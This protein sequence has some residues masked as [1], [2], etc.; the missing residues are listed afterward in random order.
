M[1][2]KIK[3][4][5]SYSAIREQLK[6][7]NA[8]RKALKVLSFAGIKNK[9]LNKILDQVPAMQ[10]QWEELTSAPDRFN[11]IFSAFG[12]IAHESMNSELMERAVTLAEKDKFE[13][14]NNLLIN[15]YCSE[16]IKWPI[17]WLK[18]IPA[19]EKRYD[20]I[21]LAYKDSLNERY[22][23]AV[24]PLLMIIDGGVNDI[25]KNKGFFTPSTDL[26][27][28]DSIAAHS[29]GLSVIRNVFNAKRNK[30]NTDPISLPYRNG[31]LHGRD[32]NYANK[33]VTAKCWATLI[34]IHDWAKAIQEKRKAPPSA[35]ERVS[36]RETLIKASE[37]HKRNED[38]SR[39][40]E[41]WKPRNIVIGVDIPF[42]GNESDYEDST[43]EIE[44]IRFAIYWQKK[45]YG[46]IARQIHQFSK[47]KEQIPTEAKRMR[48]ILSNKIL[49]DYSLKK[50][51]DKAPAISEVT[52]NVEFEC[53]TELKN[54]DITLRFICEGENGRPGMFGFSDCKWQFIDTFLYSLD[55]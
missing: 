9:E 54:K 47:N 17:T 43:P 19:F 48:E 40:V 22:Y 21:L 6:G 32:I 44:A 28:W 20:L 34:A 30:T 50:I 2:D 15:H 45:N 37:N 18:H 25:D 46:N 16:E 41:A 27:A 51:E 26:T 38:I 36:F 14:G 10:K 4:N 29:S 49:H 42:K 11:K 8:F 31:I 12:W 55:M 1:M 3:D 52:L 33:E 24:P 13:E 5:P 7:A 35:K 23:S 39:R 53:E